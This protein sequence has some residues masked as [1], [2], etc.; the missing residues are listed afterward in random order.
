MAVKLVLHVL[1]TEAFLQVP[2]GSIERWA[3]F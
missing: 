1:P 3:A 2:Y